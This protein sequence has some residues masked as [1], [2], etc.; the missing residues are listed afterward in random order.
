[1]PQIPDSEQ[2]HV[3]GSREDRS[4]QSV[5]P[6]QP[7]ESDLTG[8]RGPIPS[9]SLPKGGGAIRGMGE[10]FSVNAPTATESVTVPLP[11]SPSLSGSGPQPSLSYDSGAGNGPFGFGRRFSLP[12][13]TRETDKGLPHYGDG[14]ESDTFIPSETEDLVFILDSASIGDGMGQAHPES[15]LV[16]SEK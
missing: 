8:G 4:P 1:M 9:I 16:S 15:N 11:F 13:I 7:G 12:A 5:A 3:M 2:Q 6:C 10:K 14:E